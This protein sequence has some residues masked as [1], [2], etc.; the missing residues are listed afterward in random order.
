MERTY[1]FLG[2][3]IALGI[4]AL[5]ITLFSDGR[6]IAQAVRAALVENVDEPGRHPYVENSACV[7]GNCILTFSAVPSGERLVVTS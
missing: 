2:I 6:L 5:L 7:T 1:R 3:G 4:L